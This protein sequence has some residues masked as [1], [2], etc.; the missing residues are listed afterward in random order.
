MLSK[1]SV[2]SGLGASCLVTRSPS[3]YKYDP[4]TGGIQMVTFMSVQLS[5]RPKHW[6]EM[7]KELVTLEWRGKRLVT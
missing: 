4:H 1:N 7:V 6:A 3:G 2:L 5:I